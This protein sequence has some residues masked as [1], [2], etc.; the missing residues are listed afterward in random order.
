MPLTL[1]RRHLLMHSAATLV[2]AA[3]PV[4]LSAI[5]ISE[6]ADRRFVKSLL[7]RMTIEE[8]AG[9]LSLFT[10]PFATEVN[11]VTGPPPRVKEVQAMV[12]AGGAIGFFGSHDPAFL[13]SLQKIAVEESRLRIPLIFAGDV[14]H[15]LRT[16]YP[17]PLGEAASFDPDLCYRTARATAQEAS[18]FGLHWFFAPMVDVARDQRWGRVTEG[19]GEDP[20]LVSRLS[21][22]RVRGFQGPDL[23]AED[24]MLACPKHFAAYGA[25]EGGMDYNSVEISDVALHQVHLPPF[26]AAFDAGALSV[27]SAFNDIGGVPSTGNRH[28]LTDI[29]RGQWKFPGLVVSDYESEKELV[30]HGFAEEEEDAVIKALTAGCDVSMQSGLYNKHIPALVRS[31]RL[32]IR[33]VDEAVRRVLRVKQALGLFENP[34]R[35]LSPDRRAQVEG[36]PPMVALAREAAR[37]SIVLLKNEGDLLPLPKSGKSF[38]FIGPYVSDTVHAFGAWAATGDSSKVV[39]LEESVR[40]TLGADARISFTRACTPTQPIDGGIDAAIAAATAADIAVLFVGES[41]TRSGEAASTV[42]ITIPSHQ[43]A[44]VEAVVGTGKPTVVLL[45][46]GRGLALTGECLNAQAIVAT[47]FLGSQTGHGITDILFGDH[48]PQGRLPVSFPQSAG[49]QPYYYN[50]RPT[51]R[52]QT[53]PSQ[54]SHKARYLE[55]SNEAL[56]PFGHGLGYAPISYGPTQLDRDTVHKGETLLV[57][58]TLTNSGK[59]TQREVAQLYI[60]DRVA[61]ITQPVRVLRNIQ[62]VD[63]EAGQSHMVEFELRSEDLAHIHEDLAN[64]ADAGLFD[65]WIAPD[66]TRGISASVRLI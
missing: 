18:G 43:Q 24:G 57:R 20:W 8:K 11:P 37:K 66:A 42:S 33:I 7:R 34:Y 19:A 22:A 9:Q 13:R 53:N 41:T 58:A 35:S 5:R 3:I 39:T 63:I 4:D 49:Q 45:K 2:L 51:G 10:A 23:K 36:T 47:W 52:P 25:V 48:A 61:S 38:A 14:I 30:A 17:T 29:L 55:V 1:Q 27:M 50:H 46:H 12:R 44:L 40:S 65:I 28:L 60:H 54:K 32:P 31:G 16:I 26:K 62:H 64:E 21:Q 59:R 15:G 56:F 6:E